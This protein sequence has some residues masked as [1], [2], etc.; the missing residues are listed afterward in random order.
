MD[1][2]VTG[3][4]IA[5]GASILGGLMGSNSE[6][7]A[8]KESK[9]QFEIQAN[10]AIQRRVADARKAGV[11]PLFALGASANISPTISAGA[12]NSMGDAVS[13]AGA[14]IGDM[15]ASRSGR[16]HQKTLQT[17]QLAQG[18]ADLR[19]T[20]A[21]TALDMAQTQ[22]ALSEA[23]RAQVNANASQDGIGVTEVPHTPKKLKT[24]LGTWQT[25]DAVPT[26]AVEDEY[27]DVVGWTY[28]T[29]RVI[30]D[31]GNQLRNKAIQGAARAINKTRNYKPRKY[32]GQYR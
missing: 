25:G 9:R 12:S 4:L 32:R 8:V 1:P 16:E 15:L 7:K 13:R 5:G 6:K 17:M 10:E 22:L 18:A 26:Q 29:G 21:A 23:K 14:Q 31:A 3:S 30:I 19:R 28:G 11:H 27:G 2:V 24:P 20:N